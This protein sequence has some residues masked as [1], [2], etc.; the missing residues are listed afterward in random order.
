MMP[1]L[2]QSVPPA[3]KGILILFFFSDEEALSL[4]LEVD[5]MQRR[6]GKEILQTFLAFASQLLLYG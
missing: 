3:G 2:R 5:M 1:S 4:W 6:E